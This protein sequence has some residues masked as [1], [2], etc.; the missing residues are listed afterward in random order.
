MGTETPQC[1]PSFALGFPV[2]GA[3]SS[4]MA[5]IQEECPCAHRGSESQRRR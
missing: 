1:M 4:F 3:F 5:L 2:L